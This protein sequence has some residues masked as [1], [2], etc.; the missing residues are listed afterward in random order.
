MPQLDLG[1]PTDDLAGKSDEE[2]DAVLRDVDTAAL[3]AAVDDAY[4]SYLEEWSEALRAK[5]EKSKDATSGT[6]E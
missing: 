2:L 6:N 1:E 5:L 3:D 4:D